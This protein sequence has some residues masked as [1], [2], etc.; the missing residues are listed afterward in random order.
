MNRGE[1]INADPDWKQLDRGFDVLT[2]RTRRFALYFL[3][4][5]Q[6]ASIDELADV[7]TSWTHVADGE[8]GTRDRRDRIYQSL[9]HQHVPAL[10]DAGIVDHDG[11]T[12][13][14]S[15]RPCPEPI[16]DLVRL[17]CVAETGV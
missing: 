8:P 3:L 7:V 4:E 2:D 5:Q 1:P 11:E 6:S 10:D 15:M 14:V 13:T 16:R 9:V 12:D 17:S